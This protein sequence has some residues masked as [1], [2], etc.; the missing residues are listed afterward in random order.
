MH[1]IETYKAVRRR[2]GTRKTLGNLGSVP[3]STRQNNVLRGTLPGPTDGAARFY[4]K[5]APGVR[6]PLPSAAG[7]APGEAVLPVGSIKSESGAD[8]TVRVMELLRLAREQ[9]YITFDDVH[10]A[11]AQ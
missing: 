7:T 4:S 6:L 1:T 10:E 2:N 9:G 11:F 8:L 5:A 3:G